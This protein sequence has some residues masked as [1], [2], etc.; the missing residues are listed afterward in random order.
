MWFKKDFEYE[1]EDVFSL[2]DGGVVVVGHMKGGTMHTGDRA[3]LVKK[4]GTKLETKIG[5][6]ET[7]S[8]TGMVPLKKASG[9]MAVGVRLEGLQKDRVDAGDRLMIYMQ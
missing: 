1:V 9:T 6:M 7:R 5:Q 8:A 4:D 2:I 3:W